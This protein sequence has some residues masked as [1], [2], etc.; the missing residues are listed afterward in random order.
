MYHEVYQSTFASRTYSFSDQ[1]EALIPAEFYV[2][3]SIDEKIAT[4]SQSF[5]VPSRNALPDLPGKSGGALTCAL[6]EVLR[7][8]NN[9]TS[10]KKVLRDVEAKMKAKKLHVVPQLSTSR[11][12]NVETAPLDLSK[13]TGTKRAILVGINYTNQKGS[14]KSCH[15]DVETLKKYVEETLHYPTSNIETLMDDGK[16]K[17][18]TR[19][20]I[21]NALKKVVRD[22]K[23]GDSVLFFFS[24]KYIG[25]FFRSI[26]YVEF[27]RYICDIQLLTNL[28]V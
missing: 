14:L 26:N 4:S 20:N 17:S 24:G 27:L 18:P 28:C 12:L 22:S 10:L 16:S 6:L 21:M 2:Y 7:S 3:S 15:Q 9:S 11:N 19:E 23:A 1:S 5:E 8:S 25:L 13:G